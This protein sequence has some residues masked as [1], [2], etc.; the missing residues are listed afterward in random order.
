MKKYNTEEL[1][2]LE[3]DIVESYDNL[4]NNPLD[5]NGLMSH[6]GILSAVLSNLINDE[7]E[8]RNEN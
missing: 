2:T 6:V 4:K 8:S 3:K 5:L 1:L 7:L